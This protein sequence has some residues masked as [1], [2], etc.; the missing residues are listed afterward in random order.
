MYIGYDA[1]V[2]ITLEEA[3]KGYKKG[4]ALVCEDGLPSYQIIEK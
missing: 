1:R 2:S 3:I 4:F